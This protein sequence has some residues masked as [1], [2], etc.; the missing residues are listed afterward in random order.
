MVSLSS[1]RPI[2][3]SP[4]LLA[5]GVVL[6]I[7]LVAVGVLIGLAVSGGG[8]SSPTAS[9][10]SVRARQPAA[11]T[12]SQLRHTV[13]ADAA[14]LRTQHARVTYLQTRLRLSQHQ[15]AR[16]IAALHRSRRAARCW[17]ARALH[18]GQPKP[19]TCP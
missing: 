13:A 10:A 19:A 17:R 15:T 9:P 14:T 6:A 11:A 18:P 2:R 8:S 16:K 4:R 12:I 5:A 1:R 3:E 7:C